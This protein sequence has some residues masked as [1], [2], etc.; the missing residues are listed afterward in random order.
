MMYK[1][2]LLFL[3]L[4][5]YSVHSM[6]GMEAKAA[7]AATVSNLCICGQPGNLLCSRC[8][9]A[10]YC[11]AECQKKDW[12]NGHKEACAVLVLKKKLELASQNKL[13][14][15]DS[16]GYTPLMRACMRGDEATVR[17]L[18]AQGASALF[19]NKVKITAR[20]EVLGMVPSQ[21]TKI[22]TP[23]RLAAANGSMGCV[24]ALV[25]LVPSAISHD[26]TCEGPTALVL[27]LHA[28]QTD[29]VTFLISKGAR[30]EGPFSDEGGTLLHELFCGS[31]GVSALQ[32]KSCAM[33]PLPLLTYLVEECKIDI[34]SQN[35]SGSTP[36]HIVTNF[37]SVEAAKLLI[38]RFHANPHLTD[39]RGA[40]PL[41]SARTLKDLMRRQLMGQVRINFDPLITYL[42]SRT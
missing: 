2:I 28:Y 40:T 41:D 21:S 42:A 38:E 17:S 19:S 3:G 36:L 26:E 25:E 31:F 23:L 29:V 27:A 20:M 4:I 32:K 39:R 14:I 1:K 8:A 24:K 30:I 15:A 33:P 12:T 5:T 37:G 16:E 18:L 13:S 7:P 35:Q 6:V 34:D 22:F 9:T 10:R 11:G